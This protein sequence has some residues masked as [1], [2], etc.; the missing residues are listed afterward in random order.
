MN[1]DTHNKYFRDI[2]YNTNT[3]VSWRSES[4]QDSYKEAQ[5][6]IYEQ[7]VIELIKSCKHLQSA[8]EINSYHGTIPS[9][10][11]VGCSIVSTIPMYMLQM[12]LF[13]YGLTWTRIQCT[14]LRHLNLWPNFS[15][16]GMSIREDRTMV[17][18]P[19][20]H[21]IYLPLKS[22]ISYYV[23]LHEFYYSSNYILVLN[24]FSSDELR[25]NRK[26]K[27]YQEYLPSEVYI[28]DP[29][30]F[31]KSKIKTGK[32]KIFKASEADVSCNTV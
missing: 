24:V 21:H 26:V 12:K 20:H 1:L 18:E 16:S 11:I 2:A 15:V 23:G 10:T 22:L 14:D 9:T 13:A 31:Q 27:T 29:T 17:M 5:E 19:D 25:D 30:F 28:L 4:F 8:Y 6:T 7:R 3:S 32:E